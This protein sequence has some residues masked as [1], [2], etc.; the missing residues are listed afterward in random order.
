MFKQIQLL[1]ALAKLIL[2]CTDVHDCRWL[3]KSAPRVWIDFLC[4]NK[5]CQTLIQSINMTF[6]KNKSWNYSHL[7]FFFS[8]LTSDPGKATYL[9]TLTLNAFIF[10]I[11]LAKAFLT[12]L[13]G[14]DKT[15]TVKLSTLICLRI[16]DCWT[17]FQTSLNTN[18]FSEQ[19]FRVDCVNRH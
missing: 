2:W 19:K 13:N 9:I 1:L 14:S 10:V 8:W 3:Y 5:Q 15:K 18:V 11:A 6:K 4:L 7:T 16:L 17:F 12:V